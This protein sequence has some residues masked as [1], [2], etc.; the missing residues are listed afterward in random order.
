MYIYFF[1]RA[2]TI[3]TNGFNIIKNFPFLVM[4]LAILQRFDKVDWGYH[5]KFS[6]ASDAS[7]EADSHAE[8]DSAKEGDLGEKGNWPAFS[9]TLNDPE[10]KPIEFTFDCP[11]STTLHLQGRGSM[12]QEVKS[13]A[14]NPFDDR[15]SLSEE[16]MVIKISRADCER[17]I[18]VDHL[19][20]AYRL[21]ETHGDIEGVDRPLP[22]NAIRGHVPVLIACGVWEEPF[23]ATF[24]RYGIKRPLTRRVVAMVFPRMNRITE[25]GG[26]DFAGAFLDCFN[27]E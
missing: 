26:L 5:P 6:S 23:T 20:K 4:F 21:A 12:V 11:P 8:G 16:E 9:V 15:R 10:G 27:C 13:D 18:E 1:D 24:E 25:L 7:G 17:M 19:K 3:R 2:G 22:A 14:T